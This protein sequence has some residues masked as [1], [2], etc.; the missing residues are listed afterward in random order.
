MR[1]ILLS[2]AALLLSYALLQ[3]ANGLFTTLLGV[4]AK[5]EGFS[6][7]LVGLIGSGYFLGMM[8]G[9]QYGV[10]VLAA[11][12]HIRAFAAFASVMSITPLIN[13]LWVDPWVWFTTRLA[14]GLCMAG[15]IMVAESWLNERASNANRGQLLA[16]Y[17]ITNYSAVGLGQFLLPLADP[18]QF[19]LFN[20]ASILF[21]L[22]LVPVLM[23]SAS[24]PQLAQPDRV[25][26]RQLYRVSP[27][28]F[29][30]SMGAGL[31]NATFY[32]LGPVFAQG[33][34]LSIAATS[35]FMASV[36]M[37]GLLLQWPVGRL[38]D[39]IDRR[40]VLGGVSLLT[41][42]AALGILAALGYPRY[43][44]YLAGVLYGGLTFTLYSLSAAHAND[45]ADPEQR[46]QTS[47]GLLIAYG[48]GASSGPLLAGAL[49]GRFGPSML[50]LWG[51]AINTLLG[52]FAL[53][54]MTRRPSRGRG[55]FV[56][57]PAEQ[58]TSKELYVAAREEPRQ[59]ERAGQAS[60]SRKTC[61]S[62]P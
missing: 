20:L 25:R 3:L 31:V 10:R 37:G 48:I 24:A 33:V 42:L 12:G 29:V 32:G 41:A 39:R 26:L 18:N 4:R 53:Y 38:S 27:L 36:I 56:A 23:T 60:S 11:V 9:V 34:G 61:S 7:E 28:G 49:M 30:G 5:L 50:F 19:Q 15:M 40:W 62:D 21:S 1:Q 35:A 6:T 47:G 51:A 17:M 45:F 13:V 55:R 2:V 59:E 46:V 43:W 14:S 58:L 54:R 52:L 16:L 8:L 44:L 22:A 57:V